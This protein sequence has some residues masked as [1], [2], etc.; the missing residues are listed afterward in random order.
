MHWSYSDIRPSLNN[1]KSGAVHSGTLERRFHSGFYSS[2]SKQNILFCGFVNRLR[3]SITNRTVLPWASWKV[4]NGLIL[5]MKVVI[6]VS[7][8]I[9][10]PEPTY[11]H[12]PH[13]FNENLAKTWSCNRVFEVIMGLSLKMAAG[14]CLTALLC[15]DDLLT[16]PAQNFFQQLLLRKWSKGPEIHR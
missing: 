1:G 10:P 6:S 14:E 12:P 16:P 15:T 3:M 7:K 5:E 11:L 9:L 4:L 8:N 13:S 2:I